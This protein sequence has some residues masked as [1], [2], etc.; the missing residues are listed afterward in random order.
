MKDSGGI[1]KKDL[2]FNVKSEIPSIRP[3]L[4]Y[5]PVLMKFKEFH[6]KIGR[7]EKKPS[8][9]ERLHSP[10][11]LATKRFLLPKNLKKKKEKP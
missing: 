7:K 11:H 6:K 10:N 3:P 5:G 1:L 2:N 4:K 9:S 8:K